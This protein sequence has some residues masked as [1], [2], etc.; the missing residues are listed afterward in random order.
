MRVSEIAVR[1][2]QHVHPEASLAEAGQLMRASDCGALPVVNADLVVVGMLTDRDICLAL[3]SEDAPAS[4][5]TAGETMTRDLATCGP[6]DD[7]HVA[8]DLMARHTVRRLPVCTP[9]GRLFGILSIN[10]VLLASGPETGIRSAEVVRVL[11]TI[12]ERYR[13]KRE[14]RQI[15][16]HPTI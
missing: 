3:A 13:E 2:V 5:L 4:R 16:E 12:E 7:L 9:E 14:A 8:L 15:E 1:D 11:R 6:E 10:D